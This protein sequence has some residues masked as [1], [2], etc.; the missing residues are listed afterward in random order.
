MDTDRADADQLSEFLG[1][2]VS[3]TL[4]ERVQAAARRADRTVSS[5]VREA[6]RARLEEEQRGTGPRDLAKVFAVFLDD[7]LDEAERS[8]RALRA[9]TGAVLETEEEDLDHAKHTATQLVEVMKERPDLVDVNGAD[10]A[11][12][13]DRELFELAL[14]A[15]TEPA[16]EHA[17]RLSDL[18]E[19][20]D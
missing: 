20:G 7:D 18:D 2:N 8:R 4:K 12:L 5:W 17:L 19:D 3:K 1:A 14:E 10:V 9:A 13:T 11:E 6:I 15:A 16:G